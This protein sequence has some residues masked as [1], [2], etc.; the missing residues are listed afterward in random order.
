MHEMVKKKNGVIEIIAGFF[1]YSK[2]KAQNFYFVIEKISPQEYIHKPQ[3]EKQYFRKLCKFCSVFYLFL[4]KD[5]DSFQVKLWVVHSV[6]ECIQKSKNH[7][8]L[9]VSRYSP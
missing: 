6:D 8:T 2:A 3:V 5:Y 4:P 1:N 7:Q 9:G